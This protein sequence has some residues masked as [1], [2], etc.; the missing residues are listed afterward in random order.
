MSK[1]LPILLGKTLY[2]SEGEY[3]AMRLLSGL[4]PFYNKPKDKSMLLS[5]KQ[6]KHQARTH[7]Q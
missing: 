7:A 5:W 1:V 2:I 3:D 4:L 6:R